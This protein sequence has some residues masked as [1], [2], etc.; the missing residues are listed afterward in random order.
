MKQS[1]KRSLSANPGSRKREDN[2]TYPALGA[3]KHAGKCGVS[4]AMRRLMR[5]NSA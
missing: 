5:C 1:G 3:H 4:D 2:S